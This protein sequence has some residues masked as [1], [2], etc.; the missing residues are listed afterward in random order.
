MYVNTHLQLHT[1]SPKKN[2]YVKYGPVKQVLCKRTVRGYNLLFLFSLLSLLLKRPLD[3]QEEERGSVDGQHR[4]PL[5]G[6]RL[7]HLSL[8]AQPQAE[9][10]LLRGDSRLDLLTHTP[11]ALRF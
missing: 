3:P 8:I 7:V 11:H 2:V 9:P 4:R 10:S 5:G 1:L 6:V